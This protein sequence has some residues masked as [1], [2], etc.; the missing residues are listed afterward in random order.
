M[1]SYNPETS[2]FFLTRGIPGS[3]KSTFVGKYLENISKV[4]ESDVIRQKM[5]GLDKAG[6]ISQNDGQEVWDEINRIIYNL[7]HTG[8][9]ITL[10][11]TNIANYLLRKYKRVADKFGYEFIIIDFSNISLEKA[12]QQNLNRIFC[13][14]V[15]NKVIEKM[16]HQLIKEN[17]KLQFEVLTKEQFL[18]WVGIK[19]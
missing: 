7:L 3:G 1:K 19:E 11:A 9:S 2:Y 16:Y 8:Q 5:K 4:V 13:K 14:Q 15:S 10:D 6:K 12:L 17:A 18:D